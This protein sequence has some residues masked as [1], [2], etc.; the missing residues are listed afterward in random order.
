MNNAQHKT[1]CKILLH[2]TASCNRSTVI[3][4]QQRTGLLVIVTPSGFA[5][6]VPELRGVA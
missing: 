4:L 6:A 1:I 3:A 2:P 5:K